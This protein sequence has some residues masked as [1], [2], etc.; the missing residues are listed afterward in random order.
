MD[1][2]PKPLWGR[3]SSAEEQ[4]H[5]VVFLNSDAA[6]YITGSNLYVDGGFSAGML[7]GRLDF[8]MLTGELPASD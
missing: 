8:S 5:V 3:N 2:F 1:R 4:A 6:S 7:T